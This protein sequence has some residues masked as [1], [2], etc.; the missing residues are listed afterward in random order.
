MKRNAPAASRHTK[1]N[2]A[3]PRQNVPVS[4]KTV[5]MRIAVVCLLLSL[6]V[7]SGIFTYAKFT[8]SL[9]AQ[10]TVAAYDPLGELFSSNYLQ[11]GQGVNARTVSVAADDEIPMAIVTVCNYEQGWQTR[12]NS[13]NITYGLSLRLV[14]YDIESGGYV[15]A[16][17]GEVGAYTI[18]VERGETSF[19][20]DSSHLSDS[21]RFSS[22]TLA[23]DVASS[24]AYTVTFE[25]YQNTIFL[26]MTV[27]PL[28]VLQL[29]T[30]HG[31]LKAD[32]RMAGASSAWSG[33]FQDPTGSPPSAFDGFNYRITGVGSGTFTLRW[34]AS[35]VNLFA[36][37]LLTLLSIEGATRVGNSIT[38]PVD[39]EEINLYDLQFY[40]VNIT[41]ETWDNMSSSVVTY[42][43]TGS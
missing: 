30:L 35:K 26:E 3:N 42:D 37:S 5:L 24:N 29:S 19:T 32:L 36:Q 1:P 14:K 12:V 8:N 17:A 22:E 34:D 9:Q 40:K 4:G 31:I 20:L 43:F 23:K 18:T 28:Q 39:A 21:S 25:P 41:S 27:T 16:T 10:R 2:T 38:F 33:S 13:Q 6:L 15:S 11:A 7:S